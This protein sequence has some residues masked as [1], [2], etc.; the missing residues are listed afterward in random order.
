MLIDEIIDAPCASGIL[1]ADDELSSPGNC[2]SR[3]LWIVDRRCT[4]SS[5]CV[6]IESFE[7]IMVRSALLPQWR[8][9]QEGNSTRQEDASFSTA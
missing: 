7:R 1:R 3:F 6:D 2:G 4:D 9:Q 5:D 8:M